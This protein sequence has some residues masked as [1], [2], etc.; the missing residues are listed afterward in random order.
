MVSLI[1]S[2]ST[3]AYLVELMAF[4][5]FIYLFTMFCI[6]HYSMF[7][8]QC[9]NNPSISLLTWWW[10]YDIHKNMPSIALNVFW[11]CLGHAIIFASANDEHLE[12]WVMQHVEL[13]LSTL[14]CI[15]QVSHSFLMYYYS[16]IFVHRTETVCVSWYHSFLFILKKFNPCMYTRPIWPS[17]P[18]ILVFR[19]HPH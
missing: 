13:K 18:E 4:I 19:S 1:P 2:S 16:I 17:K 3:N 15:M 10:T 5:D 7:T 8:L 6:L 12:A 14:Y 11:S 9:M